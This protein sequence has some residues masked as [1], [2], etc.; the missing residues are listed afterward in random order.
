MSALVSAFSALVSAFIAGRHQRL[1]LAALWGALLSILLGMGYG[2]IVW[3]VSSS[4]RRDQD[5]ELARLAEIRSNAVYALQK[6]QQDATAPPCSRDF[7]A[8]MQRIAFLPDGLNEFLYAPNGIAECSTSQPKF[9]NPVALGAPDIESHDPRRPSLWIDRDLEAIGR[10]GTTGTIAE[11]G[12]FAVAI[13]PYARYQNDAAWLKKEL[14]AVGPKGKVWNVAGDR[15]LYQRLSTPARTLEARLTTVASTRCDDQRV[16][17]VASKANLLVWARDWTTILLSIVVLAA[18][19]AWICATNIVAWLNRYW[20]F[21]A[22][23]NRHLDAQSVVVAYQPIVDLRSGEVSGCEVLARWRDVDGTI[24]PP[25]RFIELVAR[26]GRTEAFTRMVADRA[27]EELSRRIPPDLRL[28]INFNVFACDLDSAKLLRIFSRFLEGERQFDLAV[29]LVE[30]QQI[31]F[32]DAQRAIPELR[33]AGVRTYIDDFGT[34]YS[35]I[36]RVANLAVHGVKLDRS[37]A[38]SPPDSI[39][40]RML[41]QV[42]EMIKTSGHL[43]VVEGVETEARLNLLRSNGIADCVQGYV[44][45]RP[46]GIDEFAAFLGSDGTAWRAR[47][48]AA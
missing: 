36:E 41:V 43:I 12:A 17:C 44:I 25:D 48:F 3:Q 29:E 37:F 22:R 7:L 23:F 42:L 34:G 45:A 13:P 27:Y 15:G 20:S 24:V 2:F 8:Q 4:I 21:E 26:T 1:L 9:E 28:E 19:F 11:L 18:L 38:M 6:L 47:D 31:D 5:A 33:R 16:Y 32:E 39:M 40:G 10:P 35:S 14:V 30:S 46:L